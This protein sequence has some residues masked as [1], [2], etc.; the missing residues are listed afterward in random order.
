[1]HCGLSP[2]AAP[3]DRAVVDVY[4]KQCALRVNAADPAVMGATLVD[5]G[6]N[7]RSGERRP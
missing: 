7:P 4:P 5:G 3:S 6:A 2:L 1:M